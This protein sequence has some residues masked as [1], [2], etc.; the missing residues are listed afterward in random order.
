MSYILDALKKSEKERVETQTP[1]LH[2]LHPPVP[3]RSGTTLE[4]KF[5]YIFLTLTFSLAIGATFYWFT[6][7]PNEHNQR[8]KD[9][10]GT[11]K[12]PAQQTSL[13]NT[14]E[15]SENTNIAAQLAP[16]PDPRPHS[17]IK[18]HP[19]IITG[20]EPIQPAKP[21]APPQARQNRPPHFINLPASVKQAIP[22]LKISGHT[23]SEAPEKRLILV[24]KQILREG[25][26]L[27]QDLRLEEITVD[28][29]IL[30]YNGIKFFKPIE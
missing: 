20:K 14:K 1:S 4:K 16:L 19:L 15:P 8:P 9:N 5:F 11:S 13:A 29:I 3:M 12:T 2:T 22:P 23:Y 7:L 18:I 28:G 10:L 30:D 21:T 25:N 17:S 6:F 24:N 27:N 26:N